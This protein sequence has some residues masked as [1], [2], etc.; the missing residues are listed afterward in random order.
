M[1]VFAPGFVHQF[2]HAAPSATLAVVYLGVFPAAIAY[3]LSN[4]ALARMPASLMTTFLYL[5]PVFAAVIAWFWLGE[6][7]AVLTV[8][9]GIVAILGVIIVQRWGQARERTSG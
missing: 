4:Y 8:V 9:G 7:P 3:V 5:S 1:L 2:P 6:V